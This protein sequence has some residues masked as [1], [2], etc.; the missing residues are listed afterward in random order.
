MKLIKRIFLVFLVIVGLGVFGIIRGAKYVVD[1]SRPVVS[2]VGDATKAVLGAAHPG[3]FRI[4]SN[5]Y[6]IK[7]ITPNDLSVINEDSRQIEFNVLDNGAEYVHTLRTAS[8]E[9]VGF[10]N[11]RV[12]ISVEDA[13][14]RLG[15]PT[16]DGGTSKKWFYNSEG[17]LLSS[18]EF[19]YSR[20]KLT[21]V[22]RITLTFDF[23]IPAGYGDATEMEIIYSARA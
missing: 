5:T 22:Y 17:Q 3:E 15:E 4:A 11:A 6:D 10:R 8:D 1:K 9:V 20:S 19:Y 7:D 14:A 21:A 2:Q 18:D 23:D 13:L 16:E 12:G